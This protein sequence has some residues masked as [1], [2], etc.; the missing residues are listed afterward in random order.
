[1]IARYCGSKNTSAAESVLIDFSIFNPSPVFFALAF[2]TFFL[3]KAVHH[4]PTD[5][6]R[7][8]LVYRPISSAP[9]RSSRSSIHSSSAPP[10]LTD[11]GTRPLRLRI[12]D[13]SRSPTAC[14]IAKIECRVH[15]HHHRARTVLQLQVSRL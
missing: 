2:T 8:F 10:G 6:E 3:F 12:S 4:S 5:Q 13:R 11:T 14:S 1:M 7:A 15:R 9:H